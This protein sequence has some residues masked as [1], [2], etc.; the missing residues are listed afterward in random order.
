MGLL[1]ICDMGYL[2]RGAEESE[3]LV[4]VI[5]ERYRRCSLGIILNLFFSEW[6]EILAN[7][8]VTAAAIDRIVHHS[9]ILQFDL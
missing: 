1:V 4:T 7:P 3:L 6:E 8:M 9:V 2:S 5:A